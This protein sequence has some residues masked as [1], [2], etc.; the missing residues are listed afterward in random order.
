[1]VARDGRGPKIAPSVTSC[2]ECL[3]W[4]LT[5]A[6]GVCL[7]CYN[8]AT[9][10]RHH[11]AEC[12]ACRRRLPVKFG[13]CRLCWCQAREDRAALGADADT[14]SAVMIAP[15][16]PHV[17]YHQLFLAGMTQRRAI[18][19]TMPR[20]Y[21]E[22]GR[23]RK[24]Q[25]APAT[26]PDTNRA[27]LVLFDEVLARDY[28]AVRVDLRRGPVPDN[29][30]LGWALHIAHTM[31]ESRGWTVT[32]RRAMQRTLVALL[33]HH[34]DGD[35]V[36]ATDARAMID[37][38]NV[39]LDNAAEILDGM[40]IWVDDR[41]PTFDTWL[42]AKLDG[43]APGIGRDAR[44]WA[45]VL[46]DGGP[47][48]RARSPDTAR[49]Y[50]R[51]VRLA[52]LDWSTRY[53]H[54]REVTR[55][56]VIAY[57]SQRRGHARQGAVTALRSLFTWAKKAGVIFANP[58]S[59]ITVGKREHPI[60]QPLTPQDIAAAVAAATTPQARVFVT[61]AAIHAARPGAIRA[62][63]LDDVDLANQR[64]TIA[65][66]DRPLDPL[67]ERVLHDWLAHRSRCWPHT[68][69]PHLLISRETALGHQPV[70]A[71]WILNLRGLPANIE[72]LRIDRQ[73]EEALAAGPDPL[74]LAELFGLAEATAIRYATNARHLLERPHEATGQSSP[75][76]RVST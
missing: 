74:H 6:Q 54:L 12:G 40:G 57:L 44:R 1:M 9:R 71:T 52:L 14:R 18:P 58:T 25:P 13:Y 56:D 34:R 10:Y 19:R 60:W 5:Y 46:H 55:D 64:L 62:L 43:L 69:N 24:P 16:L 73:L 32:A 45:R 28:A 22:K 63:R 3:A 38:Y 29:P 11:V 30:W 26:R 65:G 48:S 53:G 36:R 8:F 15:H 27:Q 66:Q 61:L 42:E 59:R 67:T 20:R 7:A 72:R 70:S 39:N 2:A 31:A 17:R 21:G 75:A 4:G 68:A 23:P 76:T 33:A 37:R 47:R 51:I 50:L 49:A 41:T 35:V